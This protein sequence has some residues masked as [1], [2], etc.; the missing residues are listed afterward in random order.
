LSNG[1]ELCTFHS[2]GLRVKY[3]VLDIT[4]ALQ[5]SETLITTFI[6]QNKKIKD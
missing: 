3:A 6:G 2:A 5:F 1:L 4:E